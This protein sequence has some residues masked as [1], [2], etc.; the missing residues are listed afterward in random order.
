MNMAPQNLGDIEIPDIEIDAGWPVSD[1]KTIEDCDDA[2]AFLM[3]AVAS[4]EYALDVEMIK[5]V[6][7]QDLQ[8]MARARCALKYKKAA[9]SIINI[10]RGRISNDAKRERQNRAD[11]ILLDYIRDQVSVDDFKKWVNESG[12]KNLDEVAA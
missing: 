11:R 10:K 9:L 4:I 1:S 12:I 8:W 6:A 7:D 5:K 3:S 2:F